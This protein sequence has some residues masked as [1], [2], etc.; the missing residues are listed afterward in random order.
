[1]IL[2]FKLIAITV[3]WV[4]GFKLAT[5]EGMIFNFITRYAEEKEGRVWEP[6]VLCIWCMPSIHSLIA[7]MLACGIGVI[8]AFSWH[9]VF[10][11][12]LVVMGS[13]FC[14]GVLWKVS[15]LV[16]MAALHHKNAAE[17][18]YLQVKDMKNQYN[19]KQKT[20]WT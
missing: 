11:Y 16:D 20:K 17:R 2:L 19:Q 5:S 4:L 1:M 7:Y 9:L 13:S 15:E 10:M 12:P 14:C 18:D 6:I 3:I 8:N